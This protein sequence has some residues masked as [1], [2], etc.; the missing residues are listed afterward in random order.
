[1]R[2]DEGNIGGDGEGAV[3]GE[4][5]G[6]RLSKRQ[7]E[8]APAGGV[9]SGGGGEAGV[10]KGEEVEAPPPVQL[11]SLLF[12]WSCFLVP[13]SDCRSGGGKRGYDSDEKR[14]LR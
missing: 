3:G 13:G 7:K 9:G 10:D 14:T 5:V 11:V 1:M 4:R 8:K 6:R 2:A 12:F